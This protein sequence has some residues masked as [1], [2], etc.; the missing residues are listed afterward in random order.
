LCKK[1]KDF[2]PGSTS[3][4]KEAKI[5]PK[6]KINSITYSSLLLQK[7]NF[8]LKKVREKKSSQTFLINLIQKCK[9]KNAKKKK[10]KNFH[11]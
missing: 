3:T 11:L 5:K 6:F 7:E 1:T 10:L 9:K 4:F 2:S 8:Q